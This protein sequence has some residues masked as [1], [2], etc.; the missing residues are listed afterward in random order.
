MFCRTALNKLYG[1]R[2]TIFL[3]HN[4]SD[5]LGLLGHCRSGKNHFNAAGKLFGSDGSAV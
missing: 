5:S 2:E 3:L 1:A 4:A